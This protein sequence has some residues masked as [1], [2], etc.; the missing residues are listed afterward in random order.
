MLTHPRTLGSLLRSSGGCR[1]VGGKKRRWAG[2]YDGRKLLRLPL[3]WRSPTM[4]CGG[5]TLA[6]LDIGF[7][8]PV[9]IEFW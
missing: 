8:G 5:D 7:P 4:T 1:I 6:L 2:S 3:Y 9:L